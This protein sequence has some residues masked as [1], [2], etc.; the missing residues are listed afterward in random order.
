MSM[1][2]RLEA[3]HAK[4]VKLGQWPL[5]AAAFAAMHD[6]SN[7]D[8]QIN[9]VGAIH[10]A[11]LLKNVAQPYLTAWR[12]PNPTAWASRC[13]ERLRG[14]DHDLWA[15]ISL[16]GLTV[17]EV[18]PALSKFK[19]Y[20]VRP[21]Q[22]LRNNTWI[23]MFSDSKVDEVMTCVLELGCDARTGALV[24]VARCRAIHFDTH[25]F[26]NGVLSG[27]GYGNVFMRATAPYGIVVTPTVDFEL[28]EPVSTKNPWSLRLTR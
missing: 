28:P 25:R 22:T 13:I 5:A 18:S 1:N 27:R 11:G 8:L 7:L 6:E 16:L 14:S 2:K 23:A 24:D 17:A 12:T 20:S 26:S 4:S 15:L 9:V 10:E 21:G 19:K 3:Q